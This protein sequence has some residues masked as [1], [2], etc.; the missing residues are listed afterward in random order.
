MKEVERI[1][2]ALANR[3][4]IAIVKYLK[5]KRDATVGDIAGEINLSFKATSKHLCILSTAD[6]LEKE[7]RSL[8]VYYRLAGSQKPV[9]RAIIHL[10]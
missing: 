5:N 6:I 7:Q 8:Q 2:K 1:L 9:A 10:L 3:R 4:R